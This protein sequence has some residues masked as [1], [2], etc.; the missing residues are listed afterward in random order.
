MNMQDIFSEDVGR[1]TPLVLV[2]GFLGSSEMWSPQIKFF[3]DNFR[4]IV[5][6]LPGFGKSNTID[7]CNSIECMANAILKLL[8]KK[9][10][11]NFN[12]L[13]H[14]M[15]GMIVQE[16][17]KIAGEKILKLI[18]YGTGPKG[19][20]PGRFETIDQSRKKL[21]IDGLEVTANRIAKTWFVKE[22]KA[23]YFYLCDEAGKQ[24]SI[25]ATDNGLIAMKNWDGVENLRNIKNETLI[26]WGNQ[27]KAYN[28]NQVETLKNHIPNSDLKIID[29]CS[30]N[31]HL[32]KPDEFNAIVEDFLKRN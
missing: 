15:G 19:N 7:S 17:T 2:H 20:I 30:H 1:G 16:M 4:V 25:E 32:E 3:K 14:S 27:D 10:I 18:C 28:F 24:T 6:A 22:E 26:V 12:L 23:K 21:K 8:E 11:E 9:K 5:P 29:G 13:G 31:V